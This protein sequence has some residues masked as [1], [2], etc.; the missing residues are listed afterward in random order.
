MIFRFVVI[1]RDGNNK[2]SIFFKD[3][4]Y[5]LKGICIVFEMFND[6]THYNHIK[7]ILSKWKWRLHIANY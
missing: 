5:I 1:K 4:P 7:G 6:F 2:H 3:M